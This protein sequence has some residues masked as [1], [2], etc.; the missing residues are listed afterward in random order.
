MLIFSSIKITQLLQLLG[1]TQSSLVIV[2]LDY[3]LG[4]K[5]HFQAH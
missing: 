5:D 1:K 2:I 3:R 4:S